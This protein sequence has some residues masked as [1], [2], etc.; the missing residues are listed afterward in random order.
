M[1]AALVAVPTYVGMI[2]IS[3]YGVAERSTGGVVTGVNSDGSA[4]DQ[5]APALVIAVFAPTRR[6]A[7]VARGARPRTPPPRSHGGMKARF[8][9]QGPGIRPATLGAASLSS[10]S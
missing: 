3:L 8:P 2:A 4:P 6:S 10:R 5:E 9:V 7:V 1:A